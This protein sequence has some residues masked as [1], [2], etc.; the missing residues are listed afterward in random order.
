MSVN[1]K[2]PD[3]DALRP[4]RG[5]RVSV[6]EA[7]IKKSGRKDLTLMALEEGATVGAVFTKNRFCA[8]PVQI[9]KAHLQAGHGIRAL[10]IN[11]GNANAGTGQEGLMRAS[12]TCIAL[13]RLM[14]IS[15][16]QVLPFS[17]GVIMESLPHQKIIDHLPKALDQMGQSSWGDAA[18]G[19][20]TTDTV[21]KAASR[22][23]M[24]GG[25]RV[26]ITGISKGAGMIKPNMATMLG[27]MATDASI[28]VQC[29]QDLVKA[30]ADAS[31]NRITVDG[32][33]S[34]ND[35]FVV[36]ATGKAQNT[37][38]TQ[39]TS[40]LGLE[41]FNAMQQVAIELCQSIVRDG[42]GATKFITVL[43]E[44]GQSDEECMKVA[45]AV[46]HS[47]LVKTAFFASDPNLGRILA[48]V[49][50]AGIEDLDQ[51]LI[52]LFLDDV[53]VA[54]RGGRHPQYLELEGQ[55]VMGQADITVRVQL[56]RGLHAQHV[57]TC[58]LSHEYVSINA[59][60][61]S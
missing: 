21:P 60:Y 45:Y 58:D 51:S 32:D 10:L 53:H 9:C 57:W 8:A 43:V 29:M 48:A 28:T 19:I 41:L 3:V 18:T 39:F 17:T 36:M 6:L 7:G 11:T 56:G 59:D 4:I 23:L 25:Q 27:F 52:E 2:A 50:Y 31:F 42:E 40:G 16:E 26:C 61:R 22:E 33:T 24:L 30:L 38:I 37:A 47:P 13:A 55:R 1:L 54:T 14:D 46:A 34:T 15:P 20:M 12:A 44:Q 5:L 49:G 35:S